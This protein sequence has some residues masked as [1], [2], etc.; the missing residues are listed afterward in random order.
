MASSSFIL[1][2]CILGMSIGLWKAGWN[3]VF[4]FWIRIGRVVIVS[5]FFFQRF[6][7]HLRFHLSFLVWFCL[8]LPV[9]FDGDFA[10]TVSLLYALSRLFW[11]RDFLLLRTF[12]TRSLLTLPPHHKVPISPSVVSQLHQRITHN[13]TLLPRR[14]YFDNTS[15]RTWLSSTAYQAS[16]SASSPTDRR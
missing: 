12:S 11:C 9:R 14:R 2:W 7:F 16:W 13:L 4:F 1:I 15:Q 8:C 5:F 6:R 10:Y 3:L